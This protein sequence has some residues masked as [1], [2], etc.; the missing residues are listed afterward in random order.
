MQIILASLPVYKMLLL[1]RK[2]VTSNKFYQGALTIHSFGDFCNLVIKNGKNLA[3]FFQVSHHVRP[4]QR[5]RTTVSIPKCTVT[6]QTWAI[7]IGIQLMRRQVSALKK[8][9]REIV[10]SSPSQGPFAQVI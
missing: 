2:D 4:C 3:H 1:S 8:K 10:P 7:I 5:R 9:K 6:K